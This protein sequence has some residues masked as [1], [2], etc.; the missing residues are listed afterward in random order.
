[1]DSGKEIIIYPSVLRMVK[2]LLGSIS[3]V[4]VGVFLIILGF[5][6]DMGIDAGMSKSDDSVIFGIIGIIGCLFFAFS[7]IYLVIRILVR[8][9]SVIINE[10]GFTD[11]ASAVGV[12]F[13]KWS[14]IKDFKIY[15]FMGQKFLGIELNE[16][17]GT[18]Q[19]VSIIK[20]ILLK[21]NLA[22]NYAM[23]N[24]PQNT[25]DVPLEKVYEKMISFKGRQ[26]T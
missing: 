19:R 1:M 16:V 22:L 6:I 20:R 11:N 3:F 21:M 9:P 13:L 14:E 25:I 7:S 18:L 17:E 26:L 2:L 4:L 24:V 23:I 12:G 5:N 10:E 8:K 15:D